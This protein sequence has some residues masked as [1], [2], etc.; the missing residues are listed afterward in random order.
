M[1]REIIVHGNKAADAT[2]KAKA[3]MKT[4]VAVTKNY[5]TGTADLPS[6][7]TAENVYFV[8]KAPIPTGI[9]ASRTNMSDY[10]DD[11][12]IVAKDEV[13]VLYQFSAGEEF[14]TDA[15]TT[16]TAEADIGKAVVFGTDGSVKAAPTSTASL[17]V[18][19]GEYNDA[20]HK[21]AWIAVLDT[22][23]KNAE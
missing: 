1:L 17:Y 9:N 16:L 14:A 7:D 8:Q 15:T 10:D 21:L 23:I 3:A 20:G 12:N 18:Y 4:G 13:V 2:F 19:R 22:P 6:A 5:K 11:F